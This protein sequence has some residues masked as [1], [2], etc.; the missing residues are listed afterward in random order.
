[1]SRA[2]HA[3]RRGRFMD[4]MGPRSVALFRAPSEKTRNG[5]VTFPFRQSSDIL[6]LT[7][8]AEPESALV[9]CPGAA[10]E[11]AILFVRPRDPERETW[12]GR[13]AGPDGACRDFGVDAAYPIQE[14]STRLPTLLAG[15][16][17]LHYS[18]GLDAELDAQVASLI[19]RMRLAER[20]MGSPPKRV[21]DPRCILHELRLRKSPEELEHLARAV[22]ITHEAHVAA[23]RAAKPG[24]WE[25]ELEA[26]V[27]YTFRRHGASGPGYDTIV[28]S[29]DNATILHYTEN[30]ALLAAGTLVLID[31]GAEFQSYTADVTRTF[32]CGGRFT[33][34]QRRC[35]EIVLRAQEEAIRMTRPG[36][37]ID[38]IHERTIEILVEGMLEL[39]LLQGTVKERIADGSYR[40][41]YMHRTS[42]WLGMDVHDAGAYL[43]DVGRA[44][45][46]EEGM[47]ITIEPGLY[48]PRDDS[49]APDDM[50]GIGI[51]IEDDVL[52]T[53]DGHRNLTASIPKKPDDIEATCRG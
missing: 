47:V 43:T 46:L 23:M 9:L 13:R 6:Y 12:E 19:A 40:K 21:V 41:Y 32:P 17:D 16:D 36:V 53:D 39:G 29:G 22:A 7:G 26:L 30:D 37:T 33:P 14:L 25:Y 38:D 49:A 28:G 5:D 51:R 10:K 35:Y 18:L 20:R 52:V 48:I 1:M 34:P 27:N 50:R 31:A 42:H 2:A 11:R 8:F 45:P 4:G 24:A 15:V 44:R 3:A